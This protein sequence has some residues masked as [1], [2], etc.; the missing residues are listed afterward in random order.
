MLAARSGSLLPSG[1]DVGA[2][3]PGDDHSPFNRSG[4]PADRLTYAT[5]VERG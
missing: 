5:A 2:G 4:D 1:D 3:T